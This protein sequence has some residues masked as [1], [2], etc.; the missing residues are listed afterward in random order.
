MYFFTKVYSRIT[1]SK[2]GK[3]IKDL[4]PKLTIQTI[5]S[6]HTVNLKTSLYFLLKITLYYIRHFKFYKYHTMINNFQVILRLIYY[7]IVT[8]LL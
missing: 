4:G 2:K 7:F 5:H 1:I 8:I 6:F 3:D